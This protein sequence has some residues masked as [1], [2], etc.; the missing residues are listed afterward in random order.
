MFFWSSACYDKV[1][2]PIGISA[3]LSKMSK[4]KPENNTSKDGVVIELMI[5]EVDSRTMYSQR[6]ITEIGCS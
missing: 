6:Q 4:T 5:H 3:M 2:P 1:D